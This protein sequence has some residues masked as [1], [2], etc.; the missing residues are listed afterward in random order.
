M[1]G[2]QFCRMIKMK[3]PTWSKFYKYGKI[4]NQ[5]WLRSI[6]IENEF[7]FPTPSELNDPAEC[8]P[9]I[10]DHSREEIESFLI[11]TY[12]ND[13]PNTSDLEIERIKFGVRQL[14]LQTILEE[15][16]KFL[17]KILDKKYGVFC[18]SKRPDNLALWA[19]YADNHRGYCLEFA[20]LGNYVNV[21]EVLYD[22]KLPFSLDLS[23][24][25][26]Q[27]EFLFTKTP[28]W[29]Y[30]EEARVLDKP[31]IKQFPP[32]FFKSIILGKNMSEG[33]MNM[34]IDWCKVRKVELSV[35][36]AKFNDRL[37]RMEYL[38]IE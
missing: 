3:R 19:N 28:E 5:T 1:G 23:I 26:R 37:Q 12:I 9:I 30:E 25:P 38:T 24:D 16:S 6:I 36:K 17:N 14:G 7:Y 32:H 15:M 29:A 22:K 4:T 13:N 34:I 33:H 35:K 8:K 11:A 2:S 21:Y 18:L 31:G 27:A 10:S 20:D